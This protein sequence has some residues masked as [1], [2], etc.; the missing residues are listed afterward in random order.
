MKPA[1]SVTANGADITARLVDYLLGLSITDQAGMESDELEIVVA[2]PQA[3]M[4]M[5]TLGAELSVKL[6][7]QPGGLI[8]MGRWSVDAVDLELAPRAWRIVAHAADLRGPLRSRRSV[9]W[10]NTTLGAIVGEIATR[11]GLGS[12]VSS[13]L[14]GVSIPRIDQTNESDI[15][16]LTRLGQLFDAMATVKTGYL[17]FSRRGRGLGAS[18]QPIEPVTLQLTDVTEGRVSLAQTEDYS[19][20][21]ARWRDIV[22]KQ[23]VWIRAGDGGTP[24]EGDQ[25]QGIYRL[26]G[27]FPDAETARAAAT[28]KLASLSRGT[29][30]LSLQLPG[31][32]DIAAETPVILAGFA[33][34]FDGRWITTRAQHTLDDGGY[35]LQIE[36]ERAAESAGVVTVEE[37][38]PIDE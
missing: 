8:D 21:D 30:T 13:D 4:S 37:I 20:V 31:R 38:I 17:L 2:D 33:D 6:G 27:V 3:K 19:A 15:S 11:N 1:W 10:A 26:R 14:S 28:A 22:K 34:D 32:A 9:G 29:S 23:D 16:F 18:G 35:Q 36:A 25:A 24:G 12:V 5:P 7:Y